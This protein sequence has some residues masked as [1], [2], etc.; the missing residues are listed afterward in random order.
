M[1]LSPAL[2]LVWMATTLAAVVMILA[3]RST[4]KVARRRPRRCPA[5]GRLV[6]RGRCRCTDL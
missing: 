4:S 2:A 6:D 1:T 3:A 5:C